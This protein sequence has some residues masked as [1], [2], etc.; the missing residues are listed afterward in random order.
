VYQPILDLSSLDLVGVEALVR[1]KHPGQGEIEPELFITVAE[2]AGL[3]V[4]LGRSVLRQ[5]CQQARNWRDRFGVA[6]AVSVNVSA[7]QLGDAQLVD[8]VVAAL[9]E[10]GIEPRQLVLEINESV[11]MQDTGTAAA[12]RLLAL[13]AI[14][15]R[16]AIDDFGTGYSSLSYLKRLPV[17]TL[18][19]GKSLV[20]D[21]ERSS[22]DLALVRTVLSLGETLGLDMIAEGIES[23]E[24]LKAMRRIGCRQGQGFHLCAPMSATD[25]ERILPGS[26]GQP[27]EMPAPM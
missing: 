4:E 17:D 6:V 8:D 11:V 2:E 3:I 12:D 16:L 5:A 22:R 23:V 21:V 19:I 27:M 7:H 14:G 26:F 10:T 9:N 13:K 25:L 15:V 24:Q 20:H 18:K 1:W